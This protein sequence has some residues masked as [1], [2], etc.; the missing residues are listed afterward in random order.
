MK[1]ILV[2]CVLLGI[3]GCS[4]KLRPLEYYLAYKNMKWLEGSWEGMAD[5][6]PFCESW[7]FA[8]DTLMVNKNL[9]CE[10]GAVKEEGA[11]IQVIDRQ[12]YYTNQPKS[13]AK[14]LTWTLVDCDTTHIRFV[15]P[16]APYS[17]TIVFDHIENDQWRATLTTKGKSIVYVLH[18]K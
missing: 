9:I 15:N 6:K 18:R 13:G 1:N 3:I 14:L 4:S 2:I 8:N 11:L 7:A 17:Q 5:G 10:T 12:I 16:N